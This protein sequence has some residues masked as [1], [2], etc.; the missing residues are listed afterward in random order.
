MNCHLVA[1]E[2]RV[3]S[4]TGERVKF[5]GATFGEYRLKRLNTE[6][7]KCRRTVQKYRVF[8]DDFFENAPNICVGAFDFSFRRFNR[9]VAVCGKAFHDERFKQFECHFFRQAALMKFQFRSDDDNRTSGIIDTFTQKVLAETSL[10]AFQHIAQRFQSAISR[11]GY[12]MTSAP[13]VDKCI[14]RFLQHSFFV[15]DNNF[16]C[17]Q[18]DKFFQSVVA[19]DDAAIQII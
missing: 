3:V 16:R 2:V 1:V 7:V 17:L 11:T 6:S 4:G 5:Q 15:A 19:I 9:R 10:L 18:P 13:V 12:R 14:D 8:L